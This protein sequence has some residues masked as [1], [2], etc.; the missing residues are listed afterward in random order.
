MSPGLLQLSIIF[1]VYLGLGLSIGLY[2]SRRASGGLRSFFIADKSLPWWAILGSVVGTYAGGA[3][4]IAYI[5]SAWKLGISFLWADVGSGLG[6]LL[7]AVLLVPI[8]TRM[9]RIT[10]SEPLGERFGS[11]TRM[12]V[13]ALGLLRMLGVSTITIITVG[14]VL[15]VF[16]GV[17]SWVGSV[18][19]WAILTGYVMAGGQYGIGYTDPIQGLLMVATMV[20]AP[21]VLLFQLGHGSI[22]DGWQHVVAKIPAKNL[23]PTAVPA[24]LIVG[25]VANLLLGN[26]LRPELFRNIF[27]ARNTRE[28]VLAWVVAGCILPV[29]LLGN[30]MIGVI[31]RAF[32]LPGHVHGLD[33]VAPTIFRDHAPLWLSSLYLAALLGTV[34][35]TASAALMGSASHY[36]TDIHLKYLQPELPQNRVALLSRLAVLG[37]SLLALWWAFS[38]STILTVLLFIYSM[39]VSGALVPYIG[40]FFWPR[41]TRHGAFFAAIGGAAVAAFWNFVVIP[42]HLVHA[43][44]GKIDSVVPGLLASL[45]LGILVS[46]ATGPEFQ[47]VLR[48]SRSYGLDR[49]EAWALK[50]GPE[51][52]R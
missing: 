52:A 36:V 37:A 41:M 29:I 51:E 5:G 24:T 14:T 42:Q 7:M 2:F 33:L 12:V 28:G 21:L 16:G 34:V 43:S 23:N 4:F 26:S 8:L 9:S 48:F 13:S 49:L 18:L 15:H 20:A 19:A 6:V 46:L 27:S 45:T 30:V 50:S 25:W 1:V 11:P 31:G 44:F 38:G 3:T 35:S 32:V 17:P 39:L 40:M 10:M 47:Q 22:P